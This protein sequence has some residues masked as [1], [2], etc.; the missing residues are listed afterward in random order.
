MKKYTTNFK[1][2][3][4]M[5]FTKGLTMKIVSVLLMVC[6]LL[7]SVGCASNKTIDNVTYKTYGLLNKDDVK[8]PDIQYE[9]V[10]GNIIWGCLLVETFIAP[11]YF[12]GFSCFEPV[13]KKPAIKG[14]IN[15][16]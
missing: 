15:R 7:F 13:S 9:I 14:S 6:V 8:N 16:E 2:R 11:I 1:E 10:W 5:N 4:Q 12:F 3:R